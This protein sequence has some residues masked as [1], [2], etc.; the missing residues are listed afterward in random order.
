MTE[1]VAALR[2]DLS[3]PESRFI[4]DRALENLDRDAVVPEVCMNGGWPQPYMPKRRNVDAHLQTLPDH[5]DDSPLR[6]R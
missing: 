6:V 2:Y 3:F 4:L 5:Y 1:T